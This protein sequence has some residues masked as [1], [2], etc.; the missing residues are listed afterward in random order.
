MI[1]DP[2][3]YFY[4]FWIPGYLQ[5][6]V[7]LSLPELGLVGGLPYI[8]AM[9]TCVVLGRF[10]DRHAARGHDPIRV[11]LRLFA[12]TAALMPLGALITMTS[13][14]TIALLI[15]TIVITVCQTWFVGFNVLL[16][17][18]FP[19]KVNASAVG[20]LGAVG[21]STSLLLNLLAGFILAQFDYA[22][23][24]A[25]LAILHPISAVILIV[26]IGRSRSK[27]TVP[28]AA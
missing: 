26:V 18:L 19:V 12:I 9:L 3:W 22:G 24:L 14:P 8:V 13:S 17:G 27:N 15:I 21:A 20:M 1:S 2:V 23:L 6:R 10:V 16:A 7:G 5:E 11:Q 25:G 4:L 28:N